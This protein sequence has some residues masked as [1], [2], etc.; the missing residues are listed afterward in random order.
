[1]IFQTFEPYNDEIEEIEE[2]EENQENQENEEKITE[3]NS[4]ECFICFENNPKPFKL[5]DQIL[6]FKLC[7]CNGLIHDKCL[8]TWYDKTGQCPICRIKFDN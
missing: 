8:E 5:K 2:I 1:M 4:T 7:N 3:S 6:Y